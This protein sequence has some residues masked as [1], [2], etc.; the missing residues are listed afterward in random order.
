M[1]VVRKKPKIIMGY[2]DTTTLLSYFNQ[3]GLVTLHGPMIM[4]G[5]S[6]WVSLG[7]TF[8]NHIKTFYLKIQSIMF[9]R[10]LAH[11]VRDI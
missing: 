7:E 3:L 11:I 6:Q 2:S 5:F 1:E 9:I 10:P 8:H 4:S